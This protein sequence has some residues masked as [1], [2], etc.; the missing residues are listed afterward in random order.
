[1]EYLLIEINKIY[2]KDCISWIK[3]VAD[4]TIDLVIIDPPY[5]I[6]KKLRKL[7]V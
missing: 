7:I 2:N 3:D 6:R 5:K 1:M 4:N